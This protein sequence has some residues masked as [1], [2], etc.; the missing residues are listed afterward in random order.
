MDSMVGTQVRVSGVITRRADLPDLPAAAPDKNGTAGSE[1]RTMETIDK[2][3]LAKIDDASIAVVA[4]SCGG[5]ADRSDKARP[6][7]GKKTKG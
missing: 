7:A 4:D 3:D 1:P 2:G 5:H 6:S